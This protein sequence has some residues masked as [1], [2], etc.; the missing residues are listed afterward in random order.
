[1]LRKFDEQIE[2]NNLQIDN[3]E[4]TLAELK[5]KDEQT[6]A[7]GEE[8]VSAIEEI[9][10]NKTI[11]E[12]RLGECKKILETFQVEISKINEEKVKI[13]QQLEQV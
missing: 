4:K 2:T 10:Q 6:T 7:D 13:Q 5:R 3:A 1:M 11:C 8:V 12:E 9:T